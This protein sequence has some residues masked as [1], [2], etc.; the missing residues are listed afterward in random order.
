[1]LF[2]CLAQA[3][4]LSAPVMGPAHSSF[5]YPH[6]SF[7]S[8]NQVPMAN[9]WSPS[10][11]LPL[12]DNAVSCLESDTLPLHPGDHDIEPLHDVRPRVHYA[13]AASLSCLSTSRHFS[14]LPRP[15]SLLVFPSANQLHPPSCLSFCF[16]RT[17]PKALVFVPILHTQIAIPIHLDDQLLFKISIR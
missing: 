10:R 7:S 1:M 14:P 3:P 6:L 15:P 4:P 8:S 12:V 11:A 5:S 16:S 9:S 17:Q 2:W 13:E